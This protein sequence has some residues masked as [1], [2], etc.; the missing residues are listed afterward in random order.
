MFKRTFGRLRAGFVIKCYIIG[1]IFSY[2]EISQ[3]LVNHV[4]PEMAWANNPHILIPLVIWCFIWYPFG[5]AFWERLK[6]MSNSNTVVQE[7]IFVYWFLALI[8]YILWYGLG[9][10]FGP[11]EFILLLLGY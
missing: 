6:E 10:V 8:K 4:D 7:N 1:A 5:L 2:A 11:I 9:I 3:N